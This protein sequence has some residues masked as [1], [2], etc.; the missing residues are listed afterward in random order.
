MKTRAE[1][2][3]DF[4]SSLSKYY[5]VEAH[6]GLLKSIDKDISEYDLRQK[7][8][9]ELY[10]TGSK[11]YLT[12]TDGVVRRDRL[13]DFIHEEGVLNERVKMV[14]YF[15]FLFRDR[16][17]R[18]FICEK[19]GGREGKWNTSIFRARSSS[20]FDGVGGHKAFTNLRQFLFQTGILDETNY[21][22]RIPELASWFPV[23]VRIAADSLLDDPTRKSFLADPQ[24]FLTRHRLNALLNATPEELAS[25]QIGG[26][27]E[28]PDDLLPTIELPEGS[29]T[30]S[31]GFQTWDRV[32]PAK[33]S[34]RQPQPFETDPMSLERANYQH[35][36]LEKA[37]ADLCRN[38]GHKV[39]T[40]RHID[41][42]SETKGVSI[43]FEMKSCPP[44]AVR[45]QVRRA[46]SQ[47]LEYR[48]LYRDKLK[49]DVRLCA[50][51][52]RRPSGSVAWLGE[53]VES[54]EIG[55]VWRNAENG[56]LRCAEYTKRLL[57]DVLPMLGNQEF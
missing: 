25:L 36:V 11:R 37:I 44:G 14:M 43:L 35:W 39:K 18:D 51:V 34:N 33:R 19:V 52:E 10:A 9:R 46:I 49:A 41:L 1:I 22:V 47:L 6:Y 31:G 21:L 57:G 17:Y 50:V 29:T 4:I 42:L 15:L 40:N 2:L 28:Q 5:R 56:R 26:T 8:D 38:Q 7:F 54:L 30:I 13:I 12:V 3:P 24:G 53:F 48:F 32:P 20:Y 27:L 16:R 23:A 55:L 45:A